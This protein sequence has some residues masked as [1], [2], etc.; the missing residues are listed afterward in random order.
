ME[1]ISKN[2]INFRLD[3]IKNKEELNYMGELT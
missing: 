3:K 2:D 1:N